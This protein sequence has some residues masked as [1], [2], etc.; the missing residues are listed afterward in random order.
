LLFYEILY[1]FQDNTL[2]V[3]IYYWTQIMADI[4]GSRKC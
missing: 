4:K 1:S 3:F 2:D